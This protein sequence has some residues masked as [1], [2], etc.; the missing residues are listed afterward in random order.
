MFVSYVNQEKR[1]S[2]KNELLSVS[3]GR[4]YMR[5]QNHHLQT[6]CKESES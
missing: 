2:Y 3:R 6:S 5:D 4:P 1:M